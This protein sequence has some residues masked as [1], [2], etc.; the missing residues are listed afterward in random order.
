MILRE[1]MGS[2]LGGREGPRS[3]I[4][5]QEATTGRVVLL[6]LHSGRKQGPQLAEGKWGGER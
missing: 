2:I 5:V 6:V 4:S 3:L 1:A